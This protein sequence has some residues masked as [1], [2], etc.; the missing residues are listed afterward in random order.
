MLWDTQNIDELERRM[1]YLPVKLDD[2]KLCLTF[3]MTA[4]FHS[5]TGRTRIEF[6]T[7]GEFAIGIH[8]RYQRLQGLRGKMEAGW[9][10]MN[11]L[12]IIQT[13]QASTMSCTSVDVVRNM[14]LSS[15]TLRVPVEE[16]RRC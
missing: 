4:I 13:S 8:R 6:G 2:I 11:D 12:I 16:C 5:I 3:T 15:G 1:R 10:R 9:A 7:A 14:L